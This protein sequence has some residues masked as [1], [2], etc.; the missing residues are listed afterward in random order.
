MTDQKT[1]NHAFARSRSNAGLCVNANQWPV[2]LEIKR[3]IAPPDKWHWCVIFNSGHIYAVSETFDSAEICV[4]DAGEAGM[5]ALHG[6]ERCL[7]HNVKVRDRPLLGDPASPP[8][9]T[10]H[11]ERSRS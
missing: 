4:V 11:S 10:A 2:R 6:A 1:Q 8:G 5:D 3:H 9:W 7:T